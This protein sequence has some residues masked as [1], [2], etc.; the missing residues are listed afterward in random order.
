M[1]MKK[2]MNFSPYFPLMIGTLGLVLLVSIA[3]NLPTSF[4]SQDA[5]EEIT[6]TIGVEGGIV[7]GP[8]QVELIVPEGA[9]AQPVEIRLTVGGTPPELP[10]ETD[11][12]IAGLPVEVTLPSDVNASGIFELAIPFERISSSSDDQYAVLRWDGQNWT[13]AGGIVDG[14]LIRVRTDRFSTFLPARVV[15]ALRPVSFVNEGPYDAVVMPWTYQPLDPFSGV[16]PPRLAT[17]SFA[18]GGPGLWPNTSRFLG[19]PFGTYTFCIEWDEDLDLDAD[20]KTDVFHAF[21]QGPS[22][23]LPLLVDQKDPIEMD[24]AEEVRFR[25]DPIGKLEGRCEQDEIAIASELTVRL[26]PFDVRTL[27]NPPDTIAIAQ[28]DTVPPPDNVSIESVE[29]LWKS[30]DGE[31]I[32]L[33]NKGDWIAATCSDPDVTTVGV[34]FDSDYNDGWVRIL[35]DGREVWRGNIWGGAE[36]NY[37]NYLEISGL[38]PGSHTI[39]VEN[40]GVDGGGGD[41]DT[42]IRYFGFSSVPIQAP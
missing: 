8:A 31:K 3:C 4:A 34:Y 29:N 28:Y 7:T 24:F 42:A 12:E 23:D 1:I 38:A 41:D 20:G 11:I 6:A 39:M 37:R 19:L 9:F 5:M 30:T 21:L 27:S 10:A 33:Y 2:W 36:G 18:P 22:T 13:S 25:T 14:D 35:V 17:A 26:L 15:W 40:L 16:L 32:A